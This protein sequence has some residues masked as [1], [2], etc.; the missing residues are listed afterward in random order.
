MPRPKKK[1]MSRKRLHG[2]IWTV[3]MAFLAVACLACIEVS[4]PTTITLSEDVVYTAT[5]SKALPV[6]VESVRFDWEL[7]VSPEDDPRSLV[8]HWHPR[9]LY[10]V[11]QSGE[12]TGTF[13]FNTADILQWVK[14]HWDWDAEDLG[15]EIWVNA[16]ANVHSTLELPPPRIRDRMRVTIDKGGDATPPSSR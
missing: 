8:L 4:G 2:A 3:A 10:P 5:V 7:D 1:G 11:D 15:D 12:V 13:T 6:V 16:V 9:E 14:S